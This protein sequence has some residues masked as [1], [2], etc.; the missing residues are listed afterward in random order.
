MS[1]IFRKSPGSDPG[2]PP[3]PVVTLRQVSPQRCSTIWQNI[4]FTTTFRAVPCWFAQG[5]L[6]LSFLHSRQSYRVAKKIPSQKYFFIMPKKKS[7]FFLK[8][9]KNR[10]IGLFEKSNFSKNRFL[11]FSEKNW[12]IS[13]IFRNFPKKYFFGKLFRHEKIIFFVRDFFLVWYGYVVY[14]NKVLSDPQASQQRAAWRNVSANIAFSR[15]FV[16]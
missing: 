8:I 16:V 2:N 3:P 7:R 11:R 10:K 12:K 13:G 14:K 5:L 9:K 6:R 15:F 1:R 4:F